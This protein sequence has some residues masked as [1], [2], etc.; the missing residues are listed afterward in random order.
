KMQFEA[1][2]AGT[3]AG[4][5]IPIG[6][7]FD[8][9]DCTYGC[10]L[11][12]GLL[13]NTFWNLEFRPML[14]K[15]TFRSYNPG[16]EFRPTEKLTIDGHFN[17]TDS[18]F[19]RDMPSVLLAT[20]SAPSIISYDNTASGQPPVYGSNINYNDPSQFGW[21]QSANSLTGMRMDLFERTNTTHGARV[22]VN[23]GDSDFSIKVGGSWDD[24][25]RRYRGYSA[26]DGWQNVVC[27][28]NMNYRF[29]PSNTATQ[30]SCDGRN[31]PGVMANAATLYPG[32]GT[33][34]TAGVTTGLAYLGSVVPNNLVT[35]YARASDHGFITLDWDKFAKDTDYQYF[36]DNIHRAF[37]N[38]SGGYIREVVEGT[39]VE[40]NGRANILGRTL[41]YNAG[42]RY[43]HTEQTI[44][45]LTAVADPRNATLRQGG[46]YDVIGVWEYET[47]RYHNIMPSATFAYNITP[48]LI[49]RAS[50]SQSMTRAN[51]ADLKQTRV[52]VN[53]QSVRTATA[54]NPNLKAFQSKN[55]DLGLEYYMTRESY[56]AL[57]VFAKDITDRPATLKTMVSLADLDARFGT[58]G[59]TSAQQ[60]A[61]D[62]GGGRALQI[63]EL[64]EPVNVDSKLKV[65]GFELT[66]QQNLDMLPIKGFGL[67]ANFTY[68][69][70]TDEAPGSSP[71]SGVPPRTNNL[72]VY[73]ERNGLSARVS[74]QYTATHIANTGTGLTVPGG[75]YAYNEARSQVDMSVGM[76]LKKV[77]NFR[78][79]TNLNL[80]VWN[81]NNA[82][83]KQYT[84]FEDA[85]SDQTRPG[86]SYTLSLRTS[87]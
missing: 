42:V 56:V 29:F 32:F 41:R 48:K 28:N 1:M 64:S 70:Q 50:G 36:R 74:R 27:A 46:L 24:I 68:T 3:R 12:K 39:Y 54:T 71:V 85:V 66:W 78:Y 73:Y 15:T 77:F 4:V 37:Q 16:F 47:T 8:R 72:T 10:V 61:V 11:K 59:L 58:V 34:S 69:K 87:F 53:D 33:G 52:S 23:W 82:I 65:R 43:A 14:E 2:N 40:V 80:S 21:Y 25:E 19:Y 6:M 57:G 67:N 62:G 20:K 17:K 83:S 18:D 76:D 26:A 55:L 35:N 30:G 7:E 75:A 38:N 9:S 81:L 51:P 31:A 79:N 63:L 45:N 86:R 84:Q 13:A 60:T 5:P 22:N 44:G 49:A